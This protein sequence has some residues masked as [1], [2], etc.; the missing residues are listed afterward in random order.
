MRRRQ[1]IRRMFEKTVDLDLNFGEVTLGWKL[2]QQLLK[3]ACDV[4]ENNFGYFFWSVCCKNESRKGKGKKQG[5][6]SPK[7]RRDRKNEG[8]LELREKQKA[9]FLKLEFAIIMERYPVMRLVNVLRYNSPS[10]RQIRRLI[11]RPKW[12]GSKSEADSPIAPEPIKY[13]S[14]VNA[15]FAVLSGVEMLIHR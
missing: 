3:H 2:A 10:K 14:K 5:A 8:I 7:K 1:Q 13:T 12:L 6:V 15:P 9:A 11:G 4:I